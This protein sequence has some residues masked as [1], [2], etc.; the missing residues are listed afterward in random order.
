VGYADGSSA[1]L[2]LRRPPGHAIGKVC[3]H[4]PFARVEAGLDMATVAWIVLA[5]L[6]TVLILFVASHT[7]EW[8]D[9]HFPKS[10]L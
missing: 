9:R 1:G 2:P 5:A 8:L 10:R 6:L 7:F 3:A 4:A